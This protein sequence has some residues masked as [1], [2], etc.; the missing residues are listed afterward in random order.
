M[1]HAG[2]LRVFDDNGIFDS[3]YECA[4]SPATPSD[5]GC[6]LGTFVLRRDEFGDFVLQGNLGTLVLRGNLGTFVLRGMNFG[7]F[8]YYEGMSWRPLLM[9]R[10]GDRR[11]S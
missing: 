9:L 4:N 1:S 6:H 7:Y 5:K 11:A 10:R 8:L 2:G 3:N